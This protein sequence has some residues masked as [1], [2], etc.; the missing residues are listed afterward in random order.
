[1]TSKDRDN[2][3]TPMDGITTR[4]TYDDLGRPTLVQE[5][6]GISGKERLTVTEYSDTER[7]VVVRSDLA[8]TGDGKLVVVKHYDQLGRLFLSRQL[9]DSSQ[10]ATDKAQG[11]KVQTRY[12]YAGPNS[13]SLVSNPYRA[14]VASSETDSTMGWALTWFD[15]AGRPVE[16]LQYAGAGIPTPIGGTNSAWTGSVVTTYDANATTVRDQASKFRQSLIDGLGR[17]TKV[18]EDPIV[19]GQNP[20]GTPLDTFYTYD[21]QS[22][23]TQVTQGVQTRSFTYSSLSRLVSATNPENG[24]VSYVYDDNGNLTRRTD[25]RGVVKQFLPYDAFN[26]P[27]QWNFTGT[28]LPA[29]ST[30][31]VN[32]T[33]GTSAS[34]CGNYSVGKLCSASSRI[35]NST[36]VFSSTSYS[37]YEPLGAV[38]NTLQTVQITFGTNQSYAM[39]LG[40]NLAGGVTSITYPSGKMVLTQYDPA[41]RVAGVSNST[42]SFYYAGAAGTDVTNRIQYAAHGATQQMK[43]GNL[44]WEDARFNSRLQTLW[45]G[46]GQTPTLL[47]TETLTPAASNRLLLGYGYTGG[48]Q[49]A[50]NGNILSQSIQI[51]ST[52]FTQRRMVPL[53]HLSTSC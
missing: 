25:A 41:G 16:V 50:N 19:A 40:Y 39:S 17:L 27:S 37:G 46:V 7:R 13:Y 14:S 35:D 52:T 29:G 34:S 53:R 1:M 8:S 9:E 42:G 31:Q 33:Y 48:S 43:L 30:T 15:Q 45:I 38:G 44:L 26:R 5:A 6:E 32:Y 22:N 36:Q 3:V 24:T 20:G 2:A 21:A 4:T 51:G 18:V 49:T 10:S 28:V 47:T 12:G 23:L 11:I